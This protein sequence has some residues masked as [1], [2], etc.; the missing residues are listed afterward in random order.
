MK[1]QSIKVDQ[2]IEFTTSSLIFGNPVLGKVIEIDDEFIKILLL[3]PV[4]G[5]AIAWSEGEIKVFRRERI[6]GVIKIL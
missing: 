1:H 2:T 3:K 5:V 6:K 4:Q